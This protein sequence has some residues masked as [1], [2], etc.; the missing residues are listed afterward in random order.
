MNYKIVETSA[1]LPDVL[2]YRNL[3][4][5]GEN[6]VVILAIGDEKGA[7]DTFVD[8]TVK[9]NSISQSKAFIRDFST[10]SA[11]D[12]CNQNNLSYE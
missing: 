5:K 1:T 10:K 6:I 7:S 9:F 8:E 11:E 2:V 4:D 12:F 3:D